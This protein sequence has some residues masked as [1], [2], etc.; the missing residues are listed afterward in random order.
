MKT[1]LL[2]CGTGCI[3]SGS[4]DVLKALNDCMPAEARVVVKVK[5]TGCHGL[6]AQGPIVRI[7]PDDICYYKVKP[8]DAPEIVASALG[9]KVV[10]RLLFHM[11]DG[12][13][14]RSQAENPF[15]RPQKKIA[16][17][18]VG[19][20]DPTDIGDYLATGGYNA[21]KKAKY[22]SPDD[23][24]SEIERSGLRGRGGAGFPT[25]RKWRQCASYKGNPKYVICN[26]DEGDPGAF[27]DCSILE[28]DPHSVIEGLCIAALAIGAQKAFFYI[29][30]EYALARKRILSAVEQARE[31]GY[32]SICGNNFDIDVVRGG[33]AFV[34]GE[35]TA[36]MASIEGRVGEPRAKYIRSV[37]RGLWDQPTVLNNVETLAVIP[38]I[39]SKGAESFAQLGTDGSKGAKVFSVVGHVRRT[40]LVEVPMGTTLREM[41]F[42][43]GGGVDKHR[44]FKA[45]QTGGPSGG[46]IPASMLDLP[47]DFDSLEQHGA[48]MGSGGMI[49]MDDRACMIEVARYYINFLSGESCGKCTPCREGLRR[50]LAILTDICEGRG[51]AGDI[52]LLRDISKT[53]SAAS[54]C[55][56]GK[57]A[58]NPVLTTLDYFPEEYE[59]HINERFCRA[60]VCRKL[61]TFAIDEDACTGCGLCIKACPADCIRGDKKQPHA[62]DPMCCVACGSCRDVCRFGAVKVEKS[63]KINEKAVTV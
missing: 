55:G 60:G 48:M 16:L 34:C 17:R 20:I 9:G 27:M 24:I 39:I 23:I 28:G 61:C 44:S 7:E 49:V 43:I 52:G 51:R 15:Y 19:S 14:V 47:V 30:D 56:L 2:C 42:D 50:I 36:L 18:N 59:E 41:I 37:Q 53:M 4:R 40:G 21:L 32:L 12:S 57:S 63:G 6:C 58:V 11:D 62:I 29:R 22:M 26:G 33:G 46:C 10:E 3:A 31:R 54:L 13:R 35:S 1:L 5:S 25:G 8:S 45:V 38:V